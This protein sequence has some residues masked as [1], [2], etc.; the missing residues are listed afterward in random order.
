M[1]LELFFFCYFGQKLIEAE[2][3]VGRKGYE[4]G[5]HEILYSYQDVSDLKKIRNMIVMVI[6]RA[7]K[8]SKIKAGGIID[9]SLMTY[10][11]ILKTSYAYVNLISQKKIH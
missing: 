8:T 10:M 5:W 3:S 11:D 9:V 7:Q 2:E 6:M 4:C 1:V